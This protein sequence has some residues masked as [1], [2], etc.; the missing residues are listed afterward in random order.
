MIELTEERN[1]NDEQFT[2][3]FRHIEM[4]TP[5]SCFTM[6]IDKYIYI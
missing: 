6:R 1:M 4:L 3:L 2:D 5:V